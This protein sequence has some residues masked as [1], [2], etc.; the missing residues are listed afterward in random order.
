ME[1]KIK[2][3]KLSILNRIEKAVTDES[4]SLTAE[5]LTVMAD[6]VNSFDIREMERKIP[7]YAEVLKEYFE[8]VKDST[9]IAE[10]AIPEKEGI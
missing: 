10:T 3:V 5:T 4:K 9:E 7:N 2:S 8:K 6:I 1:E